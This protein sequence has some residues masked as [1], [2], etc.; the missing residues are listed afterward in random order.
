M[1]KGFH[2]FF[3]FM[4][5]AVFA[6]I[7]NAGQVTLQ[8]GDDGQYINMPVTGTDTLIIPSGVTSFKVYDDGL[9]EDDNGNLGNYSNGANG[10]L[11]LRAPAGNLLKITGSINTESGCDY[12][13]VYDGNKHFEE[14]YLSTPQSL[15]LL[16][17]IVFPNLPHF[18]T[19]ELI[20]KSNQLIA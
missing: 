5:I 11:V 6:A 13:Y 16:Y 19:L 1:K 3:V 8:T 18:H 17:L 9:G 7:A 10:Y 15:L 20:S 4:L 12:L 14:K 2:V